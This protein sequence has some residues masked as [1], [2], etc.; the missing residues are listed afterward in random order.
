MKEEL[1][2]KFNQ[3]DEEQLPI[4]E[5][6]LHGGKHFAGLYAGEHVAATELCMDTFKLTQ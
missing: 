6:K 5:Y 4:A 2:N 3:L 1:I